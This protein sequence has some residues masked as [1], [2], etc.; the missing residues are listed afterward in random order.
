MTNAPDG[1]SDETRAALHELLRTVEEV[2][3]EYLAELSGEELAVGHRALMHLLGAGLDMFFESDASEPRFRRA[4]WAGRKFFGD[5]SDCIYY[6]A[7]ID[8]RAVYRISGNVAGAAYTSFTVEGGGIDER[9]PPARVVSALHDGQFDVAADGSYEIFV[10][11]EP[12]PANW[13]RLEPDAASISTRHYF[14]RATPIAADPLV[15][16]PLAID[17]VGSAPR[18]PSLTAGIARDIRRLSTFVRGLTL[19]TGRR[20]G[21]PAP[22][23]GPLPNQFNPPAA[24]TAERGYGAVDIVNM[25]TRYELGSDE[26][27]VIEGRFPTCRFASI[28]LW[29]RYLQTLDYVHHRVSLNRAQLELGPDGGF[30]AVVAQEDPGVANWI[31]TTGENTGTIFVRV[32]LPEAEVTPLTARV[33]T[34]RS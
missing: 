14:E 17:V 30:R 16:I 5:N 19:G 26:A 23:G 21:L 33:V 27:L 31:E 7:Q 9:Y 1:S 10:S 8:P 18:P 12:Q 34:T 22:V 3:A 29:N 15:H 24:W 2:D 6:T 25:M 32:I 28:A 20:P 13:L 4:H 11:S